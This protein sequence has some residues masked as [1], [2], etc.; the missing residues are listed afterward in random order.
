[1]ITLL[2]L[3]IALALLV[4]SFYIYVSSIRWDSLELRELQRV[5]LQL[6][7]ILQLIEAPDV[8]LLLQDESARL[9]LLL[10]FSDC[11]KE[12]VMRLLKSG[13]LRIS[14]TVIAGVFLLSYHVIRFKA[15]LIPGRNDLRFLSRIELALF[16]SMK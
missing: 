5:E 4:W 6:A 16:R 15:R 3:A 9:E 11:L 12:D 14:S 1:M 8:Q 2:M 7:H 10:E 13:G